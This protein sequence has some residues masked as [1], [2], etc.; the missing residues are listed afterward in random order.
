[1]SPRS[2]IEEMTK[3]ELSLMG[4]ARVGAEIFHLHRSPI[5]RGQGVEPGDGSGVVLIPGFLAPDFYLRDMAKWLTRIDY[6]PYL[7]G[8]GF[9]AD[10]P[11]LL[12]RDRLNP[13]LDRAR[14]E[15]GRKIHLIGHSL[16]GI[17]ARSIAAQRPGDIASIITLG[18]PFRGTVAHR[19]V[20]HAAK[21]VRARA[22]R[23]HADDVLPDC[24]TGHCS[25]EFVQAFRRDLPESVM[26]TAIYTRNDGVVD[27][28][29]CI[30]ENCTL[31]FE[32]KGT[33]IGLVFN[34][35]AYSIIAKRLAL[36]TSRP[37]E[38]AP[39]NGNRESL[40]PAA[41]HDV[42]SPAR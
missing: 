14:S 22:L 19:S 4:E 2:F 17:F 39:E 33:H 13:T 38:G 23:K 7:S 8:I 36:A 10:C 5:F 24:Y 31:D 37:V 1:M 28:H 41:N 30:T 26:E 20:L 42:P 29:Y 25:C 16:G 34:P 3:A 12:V 18:S 32:V 9:N 11:N 35:A 6:R 27:W 15:T 40:T 21:M